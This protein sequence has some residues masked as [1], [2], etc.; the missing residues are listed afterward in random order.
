[1]G[2]SNLT[3]WPL[4]KP[5]LS[6]KCCVILLL[7]NSWP[8]L[9]L[10][11]NVYEI[12]QPIQLLISML[13]LQ[14][15]V[16][17][18]KHCSGFQSSTSPRNARSSSFHP[19]LA[20]N[21]LKSRSSIQVHPLSSSTSTTS[22]RLKE[23]SLSRDTDQSTQ[24]SSHITF[25]RLPRSPFTHQLQSTSG[26]TPTGPIFEK[27]TVIGN[28]QDGTELRLINVQVSPNVAA[29]YKYPGQ[30]VQIKVGENKPGFYA[31][32]S[33]PDG[34]DVFTFLVK[35]TENNKWFTKLGGGDI[36]DLSFP[37]GK[38]FQIE[39]YFNSYRFDFPT[40]NIYLIATGS[41]LAPIAAA[42]ESQSLGLM[43]IPKNSFFGA[44]KATLYVG[45]RSQDRLPLQ[46]K[47]SEWAK[48]GVDVVP[49]LS[50]P[51]NSGW[52]GK[53]GYVQ[54]ALGADSVKVPRNSG[55]LLCGQ[56]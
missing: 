26:N 30:Y 9:H 51:D 55:A 15:I 28:V 42:I 36:I 3:V 49:V 10:Q 2:V 50:S 43:G 6:P 7:R 13:M 34:R 47:Y 8:C 39:E 38:G 1:M 4:N 56:R 44:R 18:F 14:A 37:Q 53:T 29:A 5:Y 41:G 17:C 32:A 31:I 12:M 54:N 48:L 24:K 23:N 45:A 19:S 16:S 25:R 52:K 20:Q 21:R 35:E 33:P 46:N 27:V 40:T 11:A 22:L